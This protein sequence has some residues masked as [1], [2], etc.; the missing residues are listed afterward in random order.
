MKVGNNEYE[1]YPELA[2]KHVEPTAF[3]SLSRNNS[4]ILMWSHYAQSHKGFC[5]GFK[6][7][8][9]FNKA[10]PIRYRRNRSS[11]NGLP[12]EYLSKDNVLKGVSLEKAIDWAYEEEERLFLCDVEKNLLDVGED[13]WG[14]PIQLNTYPLSS[15]GAVYLGI[16]S[17][18]KLES[19]VK[20]SLSR[21]SIEIPVY[22]AKKCIDQYGLEFELRT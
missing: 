1:L 21:H 4:N 9:Y 10:E 22:K 14:L 15:V 7:D 16:R 13:E 5:I 17:S 12:L 18:D 2:Q 11:L 20:A 6:R 3:V 19:Q 8:T